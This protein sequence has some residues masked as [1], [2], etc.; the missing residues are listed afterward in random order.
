MDI[1]RAYSIKATLPKTHVHFTDITTIDDHPVQHYSDDNNDDDD[2]I[3]ENNGTDNEKD[4]KEAFDLPTP[5]LCAFQSDVFS[6]HP[7]DENDY[8]IDTP[9][10]F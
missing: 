7:F 5:S 2:D 6:D 8:L 4:N 9:I 10:F 1:K 3:N